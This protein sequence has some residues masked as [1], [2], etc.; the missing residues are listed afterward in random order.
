[1]SSLPRPQTGVDYTFTW[2]DAAYTVE[3]IKVGETVLD[4]S[5]Y[6]VTEQTCTIDGEKINGNVT[7]YMKAI[8]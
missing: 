4:S 1:M 2:N 5:D 8:S 3:S 6:T 7:I